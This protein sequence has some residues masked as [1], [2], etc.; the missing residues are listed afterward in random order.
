MTTATATARPLAQHVYDC[1]MMDMWPR[2]AAQIDWAIDSPRHLGA[3]Q[4]A[5]KRG[6][7]ADDLDRVCGKGK[8]IEA[9]IR[10]HIGRCHHWD[11]EFYPTAYDM[12]STDDPEN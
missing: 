11:V 8:D 10:A 2:A 12:M 4:A 9:L 7:T 6:A 3:L 1:L 5:V